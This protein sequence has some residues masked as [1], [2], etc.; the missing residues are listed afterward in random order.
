ME[1]VGA[2]GATATGQAPSNDTIFKAQLESADRTAA[3]SVSG[4]VI[5]VANDDEPLEIVVRGTGLTPGDHGWHVH[6][7][8]CH[9]SGAVRIPLSE[10]AEGEGITGP[11]DVAESGQFEESVE[12]PQL[13]RS[14]VGAGDHS[15][16]IHM[17]PGTNP[18][19]TVACATI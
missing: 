9:A 13:G 8:A 17:N 4:E 7:G 14:M 10:T 3:P 11:I 6:A 5:V 18:G 19:P 1:E 16:H 2:P 15:L 12:V